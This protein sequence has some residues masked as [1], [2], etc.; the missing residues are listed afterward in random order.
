[1][2]PG[3]FRRDSTKTSH[4]QLDTRKCKACWKW[5]KTVIDKHSIRK[6]IQVTTLS[7]LFLMV[8]ITGLVPWLVDLLSST[9]VLRLIF[10][11][12]HDKLA[13]LLIIYLVLHIYRRKK[14]L[15]S[16]K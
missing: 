9:S 1:M 3:I 14:W 13:L 2:K 10:I 6:N 7:V 4:V 11:E 8:A 12:I 16:L 15:F 5:V